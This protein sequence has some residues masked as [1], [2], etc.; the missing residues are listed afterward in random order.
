MGN[1]QNPIFLLDKNQYDYARQ[2]TLGGNAFVKLNILKGLS[3]KSLIGINQYGR[4]DR[5]ID[6]VEVGAAERGTY[7]N[8]GINSR[9][10]LNWTWTNTIEYGLITGKHNFKAIVGSEA[11][12]SD[13]WYMSAGRSQF[14]FKDVNYITL[15]TGLRS[16]ANSDSYSQNSMSSLFGRLNYTFAD[17]YMVEAV[18]R[19]DGSSRFGTE[20][21]G[22][23]PA[24]SVGWR[25]SEESFMVSTKTWLNEL[26]IRAGYGA[27]GNDRM[28]SDY[29]PY[30]QFAYSEANAS[31]GMTG[32]NTA[33]SNVGFSQSTF[34]NTDVKWETTTT[35]NIGIDATL[36]KNFNLT[37]DVWQRRTKDMLYP[38]Q[39]PLVLG[40][41]STPSINIG[42]MKNTGMILH[43]DTQTV[44]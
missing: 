12:S 41:A 11:Y 40:T 32:N 5:N 23:F 38:K 44:H 3:V 6:Y 18:V 31:Y 35:I 15:N 42:E 29:N 16:I 24:F 13:Y 10:G 33:F 2:M 39:L 4:R 27:V 9:F 28:N 1:G 43:L 34:G 21:Y 17:K 36:L 25:V 26:K 8:F 14:P 22:I 7:D 37:L 20:K 19:R 30:T